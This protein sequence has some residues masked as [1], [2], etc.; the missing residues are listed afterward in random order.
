MAIKVSK[1]NGNARRHMSFVVF[2]ISKNKPEKSLRIGKRRISGR[3]N[4]GR[5]TVRNRGGGSKRLFRDVDFL[6][7]KNSNLTGEIK[8]LEYDP[9]RSANIALIEYEDGRKSYILATEKMK[10]GGKIICSEK[11]PIRNG[12][13]MMIKHIPAS[14]EVSNIEFKDKSGGQIARSAGTKAVLLGFDGNFALIRMPS[15][16]VRRVSAECYATVGN[17]SNADHSKEIIGKAGRK[18]SFGRRPHVRGKARNPV[19]HP[20]GGGE[21]GSPIGMPH[22]KTPWGMPALGHKTRKNHKK[23]DRLI[24]EKRK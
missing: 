12:N 10:T 4:L 5:I 17:I 19:D 14:S 11:A 20:H 8:S 13:R 18:R 2:D 15:G 16:E 23:S 6:R 21:G 7:T 3:N 1:P 24:I 9:N 22:P